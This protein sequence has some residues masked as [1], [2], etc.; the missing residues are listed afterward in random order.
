MSRT[1]KR[2]AVLITTLALILPL[3]LQAADGP[4]LVHIINN[5]TIEVDIDNDL[6][7]IKLDKQNYFNVYSFGGDDWKEIWRPR[8]LKPS[9]VST[10]H[11]KTS[12]GTSV[13][14]VDK[15][16]KYKRVRGFRVQ[17]ANVLS[18][19][20]ATRIEERA[21]ELFETVYVTF[22]SPNYRVRAGDFQRRS[23][24]DKAA[25]EARSMGFRG[26]WVVPD[27]VNVPE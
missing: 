12:N 21:K 25:S 24:A 15:E 9:V 2:V 26:A 27:R 20:Q 1:V 10:T 3:A 14:E 16:I 18:E 8:V 4:K 22:R 17:L 13:D 7:Q 5:D 19:D 11:Q 6:D 23:E